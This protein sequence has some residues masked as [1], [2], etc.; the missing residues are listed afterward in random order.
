MWFFFEWLDKVL[1][2]EAVK[3]AVPPS[4]LERKSGIEN[5]N[6]LGEFNVLYAL[7]GGDAHKLESSFHIEYDTAY[8]YLA[9]KAEEARIS[10]RMHKI[11][12]PE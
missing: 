10:R 12:Y 5:L 4:E 11:L 1:T 2:I 6:W 8:L 3:L 9:R 7:S